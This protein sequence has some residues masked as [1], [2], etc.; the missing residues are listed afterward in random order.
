MVPAE[1]LLEGYRKMMRDLAREEE[2]QFEF[3]VATTGELADRRVLET[4]KDP[5]MHALRNAV[6]HGI[7]MPH[8]RVAKGKPPQGLVSIRIES[9]RQRLKI[10]IEDDGCGI[11]AARIR[12]VAQQR[13]MLSDA[14]A[15]TASLHDLTRILFRSGFSTTRAVTNLAGRGMGLSIVY[16][17]VQRLQGEVDLRPRA[18]GG[19]TLQLSVP[20]SIAT[21][22]LLLVGC[23]GRKFAVPLFWIE[24]LLRVP[25]KDVGTIEGKPVIFHEG[26]PLPL[27]S[28]SHLLN[29]PTGPAGAGDV[30]RLFV[31][32]LNAQGERSALIV[33]A[34]LWQNEA[35]IQDLGPASPQGGKISGG[36]LLDDGSVVLVLNPVH[37]LESSSPLALRPIAALPAAVKVP[38][39]LVVDDSITTRT[40]EKSILE[41]HGYHV[42]IAVDGLEALSR[43]HA[44]A[45][46]LIITDVQM[47]RMDGFELLES[48]KKDPQL[49]HIPVIVVTSLELRADQERGMNLGADAY[50]VKRKF[51]Q[52][53]LLAAIRQIL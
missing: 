25:S 8:E 21:H 7:E 12:D 50:I 28:L 1:S 9:E 35:M 37:L 10:T 2:K 41:A 6:S 15:Q 51:D 34:F 29:L 33:D 30:D 17:A 36:V 24:K 39:I 46:D 42:R 13:K 38:S 22:K 43:L 31:L 27:Y 53:E 45:A 49:R 16:E 4:L 18:S 32:I 14:E 44:E 19:T 40:L 48:V 23:A 26:K 5:L 3:R 20:V 11:D 47:P 52:S